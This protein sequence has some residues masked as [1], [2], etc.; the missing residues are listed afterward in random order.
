MLSSLGELTGQS[1]SV[2]LGEIFQINTPRKPYSERLEGAD[3]KVSRVV[4]VSSNGEFWVSH[5]LDTIGK[6]EGMS[7]NVHIAFPVDDEDESGNKSIDKAQEA[8]L[9]LKTVRQTLVMGVKLI[10]HRVCRWTMRTSTL[11]GVLS[12]F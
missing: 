12:C 2:K 6:L 11:S 9:K 7:K 5:V 8:L 10:A 3:E 4:G 1:S